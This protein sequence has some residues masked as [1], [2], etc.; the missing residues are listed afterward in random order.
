MSHVSKSLTRS[1][2]GKARLADAGLTA[3]QHEFAATDPGLPPAAQQNVKFLLASDERCHDGATQCLEPAL[4][5]DFLDHP[6]GMHRLGQAFQ[7]H[8]SKI[9]ADKETPNLAASRRVD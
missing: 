9:L 6:P 8:R 7:G 3:Y 4:D 1:G 2:A 5:R